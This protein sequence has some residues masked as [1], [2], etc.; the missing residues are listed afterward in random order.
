MRRLISF[1][2]VL[3]LSA[4]GTPGGI[5]DSDYAKYKELG[6]PKILFS[7]T[8]E[9]NMDAM[10][11]CPDLARDPVGGRACA[12]QVIADAKSKKQTVHVGYTAGVG[13]NATYN[14]I[15]GDERS[16]CKGEFKLLDSKS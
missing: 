14:K 3:L 2:S 5:S 7:C 12:D 1:V 8:E 15:L 10:F 11:R 9:A 4:C 16:A 13:V 6:A